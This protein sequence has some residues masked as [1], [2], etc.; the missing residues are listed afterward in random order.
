MLLSRTRHK[1]LHKIKENIFHVGNFQEMLN[2]N[3]KL[4]LEW[5]MGFPGQLDEHRRF[6][7]SLLKDKGLQPEHRFLE[8]G[9]GPLTAGLP[10][11]EY[12]NRG[13]Y[14][15]VDIRPSVLNLSWAQIGKAGLSA[16]NPRLII[17]ENFGEDVLKG[18]KFDFVHSFSVLYHLTDELLDAFFSA[19]A[20]YLKPKG[21][22][23]ANINITIPSD[24]WLEFPFLCRTLEDYQRSASKAGLE[25]QSLGTLTDLGFRL[26][27]L[28]KDNLIIRTAK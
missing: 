23:F 14:T 15:G 7:L 6:Q 1:I 8:I 16:K 27:G 9:C 22:F 3:E 4:S 25:V 19:V 20:R 13:H 26:K 18:E 17:S 12:L 11:I 24:K 5:S 2:E 28:E 10:L 21:Q